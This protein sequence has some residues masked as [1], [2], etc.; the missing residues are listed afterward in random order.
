MLVLRGVT[1]DLLLPED[2]E[3]MTR[4]GPRARIVEIPGCGHAPGLNVPEQIAIVR[5]FLV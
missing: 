1:S 4:R 5:E 2:A 3:A